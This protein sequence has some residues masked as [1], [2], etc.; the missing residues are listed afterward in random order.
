MRKIITFLSVGIVLL[1]M[2]SVSGCR[3]HLDEY[4]HGRYRSHGPHGPHGP[5]G[6]HP[7]VKK[8]ISI[9]SF[10]T[11]NQCGD[12]GFTMPDGEVCKGE[13]RVI[14]WSDAT[15]LFDKTEYQEYYGRLN[16]GEESRCWQVTAYGENGTV[17]QGEYISADFSMIHGYGLAKDNKGDI[18]K[19]SY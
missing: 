4:E 19:L 1:I 6:R 7:Y 10:R 5:H 17:I 11:G 8:A 12:I 18:Y 14:P 3:I 9:D 13:Y 16:P 2:I 15:T